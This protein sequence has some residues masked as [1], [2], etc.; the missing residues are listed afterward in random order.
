MKK[1]YKGFGLWMLIFLITMFG[2]ALLP[3]EDSELL[4]RISMNVCIW[5]VALLAYII[6]KTECVYWYNG[7]EF[8]EAVEAGTERRKKFAWKHLEKFGGFASIFLVYSV[9]SYLLKMPCGIDVT[10]GTLGMCVA[11]F[12]TIKIKL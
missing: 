6:Y 9:I 8:K 5:N 1:S 4:M 11:A 12:S 7:T 3:I 2:S 10:V